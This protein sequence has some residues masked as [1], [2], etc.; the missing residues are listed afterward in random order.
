MSADHI[1]ANNFLPNMGVCKD[2][3][4]ANH[5]VY[6]SL[7]RYP[8]RIETTC[9]NEKGNLS[10]HKHMPAMRASQVPPLTDVLSDRSC[11]GGA[12]DSFVKTKGFPCTCCTVGATCS[13]CRIAH[14]KSCMAAL[15]TSIK[16]GLPCSQSH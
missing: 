11:R 12:Q 3:E 14:A 1:I 6:N 4:T 8:I 16:C 7:P 10:F 2:D 13:M 9:G 15:R 5:T